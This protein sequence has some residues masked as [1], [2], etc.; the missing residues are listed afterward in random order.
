[1]NQL[2]LVLLLHPL[3]P[4]AIVSSFKGHLRFCV[5]L[6]CP[7]CNPGAHQPTP[8][9]LKEPI[10]WVLALLC[11]TRSNLQVCQTNQTKEVKDRNPWSFI[12][13]H[14]KPTERSHADLV[15]ITLGSPYVHASVFI[16]PCHGPDSA[17]PCFSPA[18]IPSS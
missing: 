10:S 18:H 16:D 17:H 5:S 12:H 2:P 1:M 14:L 4:N 6:L 13:C 8:E 15:P 3:Q 7:H 9:L 11:P